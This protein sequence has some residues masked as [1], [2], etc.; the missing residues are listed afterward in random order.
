MFFSK[1]I[2]SNL[3]FKAL[4]IIIKLIC[5]DKTHPLHTTLIEHYLLFHYIVNNSL[6]SQNSIDILQDNN[7][8]FYQNPQIRYN[9][10]RVSCIEHEDSYRIL[11]EFTNE[12]DRKKSTELNTINEHKNKLLSHVAHEFRTP[13][14]SIIGNLEIL[15]D[16]IEF[17]SEL[18]EKHLIPALF[19]STLLLNYVNDILD[20]AQMRS[21]KLKMN[22]IKFN[23]HDHINTI[24]KIMEVLASKKNIIFD[25]LIDPTI[26]QLIVSDPNRLTQ[27]LLNLLSNA[28][29]FTLPLGKVIMKIDYEEDIKTI[30]FEISDNGIGISNENLDKLFKEFGKVVSEENSLLNPSGVGLG[31]IISQKFAEEMGPLQKSKGFEVKSEIGKGTS[32]SF[33]IEDK[34]YNI[35]EN[36]DKK[37]SS[38]GKFFPTLLDL[39]C[40]PVNVCI[41]PKILVVD[42]DMF[43]VSCLQNLLKILGYNSDFAVNG[44]DAVNKVKNRILNKCCEECKSFKMV[45]MDH[46]MP[47]LDGISATK[48]IK[49]LTHNRKLILIGCSGFTGKNDNNLF[50]DAGADFTCSKPI[51]KSKILSILDNYRNFLD[52]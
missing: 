12:T 40:F 29:K 10:I 22:Y 43:N 30:R 4:L 48:I 11:F 7:R 9:E 36:T 47:I 34:T 20:F 15:Q 51:N 17:P 23:F 28:F 44:E 8:S 35:S 21:Q 5:T 1:E 6:K 37:G 39:K 41:C 24:S 52:L 14:N 38:Y 50:F 16:L 46:Q 33:S 45:F 49:D 13:L 32:F 31:L 3:S 42:D 26:P 18:K 19:S 27:I 25:K 2:T